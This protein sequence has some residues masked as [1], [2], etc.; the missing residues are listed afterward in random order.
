MSTIG[1]RI[2]QRRI[3]LNMSQE[4]LALKI[5]YNDRSSIAKIESGERD[6][7]QRKI[8]DLANALKTT[9][10]WL[11]GYNVT[12]IRPELTAEER[13]ERQQKVEKCIADFWQA[14]ERRSRDEKGEIRKD[15]EPV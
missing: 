13:A 5:G 1:E 8:I 2:R 3:E 15:A 10:N 9:P 14:M 4:E 11:M 12:V 6:I 7:R